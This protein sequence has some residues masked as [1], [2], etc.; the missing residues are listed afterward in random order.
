MANQSAKRIAQENA[1]RLA[2]L[3]KA[4][5]AVNG[6][7]LVVRVLLQRGS[8]GWGEALLYLVTAGAE[9]LVIRHFYQMAQARYSGGV[10]VDAGA[11]LSAQGLTGGVLVDA[12]A[13]LS[14]QGL[15]SYMFDYVY[16]A[17]LAHLLSL[18]TKWAWA[19][20]LVIPA[21]AAYHLLPYIRPLLLPKAAAAADNASAAPSAADEAK[22]KKRREKK[23]RQRQRVRY[24]R[25]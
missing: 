12:G 4:A 8:L 20:F 7:Y 25:A 15:T 1:A 21:Y 11:D 22:D 14:A 6:I 16:V 3:S 9:A 23:E 19:L 24:A 17:W 10:L 2:V 5:L 18:V 13:D